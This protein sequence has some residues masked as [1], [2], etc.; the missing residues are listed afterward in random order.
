MHS[1]AVADG[2]RPVRRCLRAAQQTRHLL[3]KTSERQARI[4]IIGLWLGS[5]T[6]LADGVVGYHSQFSDY[7]D[8]S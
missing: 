5:D 6:T 1:H 7:L 4:S 2:T 8:L 3:P